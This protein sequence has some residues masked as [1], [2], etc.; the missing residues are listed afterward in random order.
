MCFESGQMTLAQGAARCVCL[1]GVQCTIHYGIKPHT[2][3]SGYWAFIM[4]IFAR[5]RQ[6][7]FFLKVMYLRIYVTLKKKI[8]GKHH[9]FILCSGCWVPPQ[10]D[11]GETRTHNLSIASL[12]YLEVLSIAPQRLRANCTDTNKQ[13]KI[14]L[15][16]YTRRHDDSGRT[17]THIR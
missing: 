9:L 15:C 11:S 7:S 8:N 12:S 1:R 14:S 17:R 2:H 10:V 16:Q 6:F 4:Y 5:R 3:K 13:Q